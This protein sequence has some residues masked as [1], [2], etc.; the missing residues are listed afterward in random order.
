MR[1][2]ITIQVIPRM[3]RAKKSIEV[4]Q[5]I[6]ISL[7]INWWFHSISL[8]I[9]FSISMSSLWIPIEHCRKPTSYKW[10]WKIHTS[11]CF[12]YDSIRVLL[13]KYAVHA[14]DS[15]LK[16][17]RSELIDIFITWSHHRDEIYEGTSG[18][19]RYEKTPKHRIN[20]DGHTQVECSN[21]FL[22]TFS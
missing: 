11:S 16:E 20:T 15:M 7:P 14:M 9:P 2:W 17:E 21:A 22:S 10:K 19:V 1:G 13:W 8:C 4:Y 6:H 3:K 18:G 12:Y 5:E